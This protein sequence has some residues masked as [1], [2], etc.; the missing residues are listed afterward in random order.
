M[1]ASILKS[2]A[3]AAFCTV[4]IATGALMASTQTASAD[5]CWIHNGTPMRIIPGGGGSRRIVYEHA[6]KSW[7]APAG[8][9]N[10]T[11]LFNGTFRNGRYEGT[12]RR[13]SKGCPGSPQT[14][15]VS[16]P[17]NSSRIVLR[18]R[19]NTGGCAMNGRMKND[20]LVFTFSHAC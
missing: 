5:S 18:G 12:A 4:T 14:Y 10:G 9:Y 8:V 15:Y 2:T 7:H 13:F 3:V 6:N 17:A 19:Y 16:G 1:L 20:T 11:L